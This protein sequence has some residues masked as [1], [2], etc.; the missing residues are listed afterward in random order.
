ITPQQTT[1]STECSVELKETATT[2]R[3]EVES[4]EVS[5]V[6]TL[7]TTA[8]ATVTP[9]LADNGVQAAAT[10]T[11]RQ[12]QVELHRQETVVGPDHLPETSE[13]QTDEQLELNT[14]QLWSD[15]DVVA[16]GEEDNSEHETVDE[17]VEVWQE[18]PLGPQL[19][20]D[21]DVVAAKNSGQLQ[22]TE[23]QQMVTVPLQETGEISENKEKPKKLVRR[24]KKPKIEDVSAQTE[25][26]PKIDQ[27]IG[28]ENQQWIKI[29]MDE[30]EA[31][32]KGQRRDV[33]LQ[34][35]VLSRVEH[36]LGRKVTIT[37]EEDDPAAA[38]TSKKTPH[39][40]LESFGEGMTKASSDEALQMT[41]AAEPRPFGKKRSTSYKN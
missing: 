26:P 10:R 23:Q 35:G 2:C 39:A 29:Y 12:T 1:V 38:S 6:P 28:T 37:S 21:F 19:W 25:E 3:P 9:L 41:R 22:S 16:V 5:C 24:K 36:L 27:G 32:R 33:G 4:V 31:V 13:T 40:A 17:H 15:F 11:D 8:M 18:T 30:L 14:V 7:S 20:S 34:T